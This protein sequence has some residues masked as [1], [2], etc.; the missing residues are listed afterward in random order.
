MH[1]G[2]LRRESSQSAAADSFGFA[3]CRASAST[4]EIVNLLFRE[5]LGSQFR[6]IIGMFYHQLE[7]SFIIF[8]F[9]SGEIMIFYNLN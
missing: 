1:P 5:P 3:P 6:F 7:G 4:P 8:F 9:I 2:W